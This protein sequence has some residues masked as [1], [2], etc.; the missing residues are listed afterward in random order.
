MQGVVALMLGTGLS[1][2]G[3]ARVWLS[4]RDLASATAITASLLMIVV[5]SIV[6]GT[7]LP[8]AM[9]KAKLD[10]A[11]AGTPPPLL[12]CFFLQLQWLI[13]RKLSCCAVRGLL[14]FP[15][16]ASHSYYRSL[17]VRFRQKHSACAAGT[18]I[19][20]VMDVS[21]VAITCATCSFVMDQLAASLAII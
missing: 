12:W 18:T 13:S 20:V 7:V 1:V 16:H 11:H 5:V 17:S 21:G 8:Y 9:A 15:V 3:F 19:Q 6:V 14:R 10:P 4:T 2:G